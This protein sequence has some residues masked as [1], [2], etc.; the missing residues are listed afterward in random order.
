MH[1]TLNK[2]HPFKRRPYYET[3]EADVIILSRPVTPSFFYKSTP[4]NTIMILTA[5]SNNL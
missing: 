2:T 1:S 3:P 5:I 4:V